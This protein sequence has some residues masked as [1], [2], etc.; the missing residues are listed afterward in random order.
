M[1]L[2]YGWG[3]LVTGVDM[4]W[5]PLDPDAA[6]EI[7]ALLESRGIAFLDS[8]HDPATMAQFVKAQPGLVPVEMLTVALVLN[9]AGAPQVRARSSRDL[10][11]PGHGTIWSSACEPWWDV[12][13]SRAAAGR[14]R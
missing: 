4:S 1:P 9:R 6:H 14:S 7:V 11:R 12:H 8:M 3:T 5:D 13:L 10:Q 2:G